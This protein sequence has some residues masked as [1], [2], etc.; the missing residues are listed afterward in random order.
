D[1]PA[2]NEIRAGP[3]PAPSISK[4]L[5]LMTPVVAALMVMA[6]PPDDVDIP[7]KPWPWMLIDLVIMP[8]PYPAGSSTSISPPATTVSWACWNVRQGSA[9][10][11]G[12]LSLPCAATKTRDCACAGL[13]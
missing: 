1:L 12:L 7:E 6:V 5:R 10:V 8:A 3:T 2:V 9:K 11:Q 13:A 4:P